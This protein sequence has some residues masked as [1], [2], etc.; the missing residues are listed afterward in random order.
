MTLSAA[1]QSTLALI[2]IFSIHP[3]TQLQRYKYTDTHSLLPTFLITHWAS[4]TAMPH[5]L[6]NYATEVRNRDITTL[7]WVA[8]LHSHTG[9]PHCLSN[10]TAQAQMQRIPT[11]KRYQNQ[12][13]I[14]PWLTHSQTTQHRRKC[15]ACQHWND[16]KSALKSECIHVRNVHFALPPLISDSHSKA[17][18]F[19]RKCKSMSYKLYTQL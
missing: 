2:G 19:R 5:S 10:Y 18:L 8:I 6:T 16:P 9:M 12:H 3:C 13:S 11:L 4:T 15:S 17:N 14:R 7:K 1:P